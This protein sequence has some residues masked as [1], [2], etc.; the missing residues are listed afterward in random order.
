MPL[1]EVR[2]GQRSAGWELRTDAKAV[3]SLLGFARRFFC[4]F[5]PVLFFCFSS[6]PDSAQS[7]S[8]PTESQIKAVYLYNFGKFIRWQPNA[9]NGGNSFDI[10]VIGKNPFGT[11][12]ESTIA[13][14]SVDGK[15][16]VARNIA[17]MQDA[18]QCRI[19]FVSSSE[20]GRLKGILAGARHLNA[21][22]VSDIPDFTL[23]GGM[24]EFVNQEGRVRFQVNVAPMSDAGLSV[25]SELL[26]VAIKVTGA[27][28]LGE[29]GR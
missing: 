26:K 1:S 28:H 12:L 23:H 25:S 3:I 9:A 27:E 5:A 14:E 10:C 19:L 13:G 16:I 20:A 11:L 24:I 2:H 17:G 18:G 21:L 7:T 22:T 8:G 6:L 4:I 15:T 29:I